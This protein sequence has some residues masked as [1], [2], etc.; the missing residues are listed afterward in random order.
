MEEGKESSKAD[1]D[2][3]IGAFLSIV[4]SFKSLGGLDDARVRLRDFPAV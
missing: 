2:V 4:R 1:H 3:A